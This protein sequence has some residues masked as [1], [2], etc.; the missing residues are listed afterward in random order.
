MSDHS[1]AL[2]PLST[3]DHAA[4]ELFAKGVLANTGLFA[5]SLIYYD[6]VNVNC[7][8]GVHFAVFISRLIQ[9]GLSY[10]QLIGLVEDDV[11][12]FLSTVTAHPVCVRDIFTNEPRS[13]IVTQ[14][15]AMQESDIK[16]PTY[17]AR[18]SLDT[19]ELR[20]AFGTLNDEDKLGATEARLYERFCKAAN[21]RVTVYDGDTDVMGSG[22]VNNAYDDYLNPVRCKAIVSSILTNIYKAQGLGSVP[23]FPVRVREMND[24]NYDAIA[25][26]PNGTVV[27]RHYDDDTSR[28]FEVDIELPT[29]GLDDEVKF[30]RMFNTL[31]LSIAG[32]AD[33]YVRCAGKMKSDFYLPPTMSQI[34]G[35]KL[36]EIDNLE[37]GRLKRKN[38]IDSIEQTADFPDVYQLVNASK[39]D[40]SAVLELRK[41]GKRFRDWLQQTSGGE[42]WKVW[43]AYHNETAKEAGFTRNVRKAIKVFGV[44]TS[45]AAGAA[46]GIAAEKVTG[47]GAESAIAAS[48]S[49]IVTK[50]LIETASEKV[51]NKL[52]DYGANL[53]TDWTPKCFGD[54]SK[55]KIAKI[56][57]DTT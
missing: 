23:D 1:T 8:N 22:I 6:S 26:N 44:L 10:D 18:K 27:V 24:S 31:P 2:V 39:I 52:F 3:S 29:A 37:V 50:K 17:F 33:L 16:E 14:F 57:K 40:F 21:S 49:A 25:H 55:D 15:L 43:Y 47:S 11:I 20:R 56:L 4:P 32:V 19:R 12:N 34:L 36:F 5:E 38:I 41:K 51:T 28:I 9:Q 45:A 48:A 53:G 13:Y 42:D 46:A 30:R 35:D 7:E 54:W